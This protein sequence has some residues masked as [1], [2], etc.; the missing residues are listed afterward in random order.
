LALCLAIAAALAGA[1]SAHAT[2]GGTALPGA[3]TP[4]QEAS[5]GD[6][7]LRLGDCGTDVKTLNW[8]L[9]SRKFGTAVG[10][11][12]RFD[13]PTEVAVKAL[14]AKS[15]LQSDGIVDTGTALAL[16]S[17]MRSNVA[18]WYGPGFF[19]TRTACGRKLTKGTIGVAHKHLPCGTRVTFFAHGNW[20]RTKVIDRGP[21]VKHRKWDL[22]Q[23]AAEQL[24]VRVTENVRAAPV[25]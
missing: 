2:S 12:K 11:G 22:T 4:C 3:P 20:L 23:A 15:K 13:G 24:D 16:K 6:R 7:T 21:Y 18:S 14:Q 10:T 17:Q 5:L 19:G 1:A 9:K 8:V 25:N